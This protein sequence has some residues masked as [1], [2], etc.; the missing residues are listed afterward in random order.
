MEGN[1]LTP[2]QEAA[3]SYREWWTLNKNI[4]P[5]QLM[6]AR[7]HLIDCVDYKLDMDK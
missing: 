3:C 7:A 5:K 6:P 1:K 2:R 4:A